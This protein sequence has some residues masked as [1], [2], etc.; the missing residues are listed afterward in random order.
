MSEVEILHKLRKILE[1]YESTTGVRIW[2]KTETGEVVEVRVTSK[3][4]LVWSG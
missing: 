1:K 2:G 3:G 4:K